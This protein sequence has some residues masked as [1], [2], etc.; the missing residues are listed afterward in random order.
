MGAENRSIR[1]AQYTVRV[2]PR[3]QNQLRVLPRHAATRLTEQL[4]QLAQSMSPEVP[5]RPRLIL[6][7]EYRALYE[8]DHDE[9]AIIVLDVSTD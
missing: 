4:F 1:S 8:I 9:G 5:V 6:S 2:A 7:R 3:A